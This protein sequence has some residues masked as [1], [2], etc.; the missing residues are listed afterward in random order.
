MPEISLTAHYGQLW[1]ARM[2]GKTGQGKYTLFEYV[3]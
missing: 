3:I 1:H 2:S